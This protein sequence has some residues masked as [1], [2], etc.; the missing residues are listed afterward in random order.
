M[1]WE[2]WDFRLN[3]LILIAD[4]LRLGPCNP[5]SPELKLFGKEIE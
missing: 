5:G 3:I 2:T 4:T 1:Q